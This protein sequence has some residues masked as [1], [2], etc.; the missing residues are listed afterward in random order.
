MTYYFPQVFAS[1]FKM[2]F[3]DLPSLTATR[4]TS[5]QSILVNIPYCSL[6]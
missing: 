3:R 5:T 1:S 2:Q 4:P 6:T